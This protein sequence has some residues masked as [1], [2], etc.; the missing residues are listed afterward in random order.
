MSDK[1]DPFDVEALESAV[2]DSATRVSAIWISFLVFS[3]YLLIAATTVT[4]RQ[5]LLADPLKLPVL[6]IDL[7]LWGFFFLA[8]ILFVILHAYVLLQVLLLGRT[9]AAYDAAVARLDLSPEE[10]ISLRQRLANTLFAQ[11]F[12]GSPREREGFIGLMLRAVVWIT[13]VIAPI[14]IL[15]AFQFSFLAYHSHIA[16]WT[17]RLLIL[18]ELMALFLIWPLAV[19]AR[20]ELWV[21]QQTAPLVACFLIIVISLSIAAFPGEPH[22]NLFT[23]KPLLSVQCERWLQQKFALID[24]RFDRLVVPH[25][26]VIDHEKLEKIEKATKDAGK[27][28]FQGERTRDLRGRNLNCA[29]ISDFA[30]L[31]RVDFTRSSLQ[32]A[33]LDYAQLQGASLTAAQLQGASLWIAQ[34][35]GASLGG[36]YLQGASLH[37]AYLQGAL[38]AGAQLQGAS[39]DSAQLQGAWLDIAELQGA[40]LNGAQLQGASLDGAQLQGAWINIAKLQGA[41]LNGAKLQGAA[42]DSA[43]LQGIDLKDSSIQSTVFWGAYVWRARNAACTPAR[44]ADPEFKDVVE[45]NRENEEISATPE[46]IAK[47]IER[48]VA[49]I[50]DAKR[51]EA[52]SEQMRKG[53]VVDPRHDDSE[54]ITKVWSACQNSPTSTMSQERFDQEHTALLRNLVCDANQNRAAIAVGIVRNWII[55]FSDHRA[56][57][58]RLA[59][60]LLGEDGKTCAATKDFDQATIDTLRKAAAYTA[61]AATA[62]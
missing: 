17:H 6:N 51:K 45:V 15:L 18:T 31:R 1:P 16:T 24:L 36:A 52:T 20:K 46:A 27:Q 47:F 13:L 4:Q 26:D 35:Q 58:A 21:R 34:L 42:L 2:N 41:S 11:I 56:F 28:P 54:A 10:N 37:G 44:I 32:G 9:T 39:L 29:D 50:P 53:L 48:S 30:D 23:L 25:V 3:L 14:L 60:G 7:P 61:P 5:L 49:E 22:I 57:S 8:P 62:R 43:Q 38:L 33:D 19:D 59:R 55:E 40:S 12:A